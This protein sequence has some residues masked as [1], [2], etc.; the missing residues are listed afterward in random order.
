MQAL[1]GALERL[2][3][4]HGFIHPSIELREIKN[5]LIG[6]SERK[7]WLCKSGALWKLLV[8][9]RE[10]G[11]SLDEASVEELLA[12]LGTLCF[13]GGSI[14]WESVLKD[15]HIQEFLSSKLQRAESPSL[16]LAVLRTVRRFVSTWWLAYGESVAFPWSAADAQALLKL[17][18]RD[19]SLVSREALATVARWA[20][21]PKGRALLLQ[22]D[23]MTL[24]LK[25]LPWALD[26]HH[27]QQGTDS[28][29]TTNR[30]GSRLSTEPE[31]QVSAILLEVLG[32]LVDDAPTAATMLA[33]VIETVPG[34]RALFRSALHDPSSRRRFFGAKTL[35][36]LHLLKALSL[37]SELGT[38]VLQVLLD[39]LQTSHLSWRDEAWSHFGLYRDRK[40]VPLL[41]YVEETGELLAKLLASSP[42]LQRIAFELDGMP[43][44]VHVLQHTREQLSACSMNKTTKE[45]KRSR[46]WR[47]SRSKPDQVRDARD[48]ISG[49]AMNRAQRRL[50]AVLQTMAFIAS[51]VEQAS[52][53]LADSKLLDLLMELLESARKTPQMT[54]PGV[55]E[56]VVQVLAT[57]MGSAHNRRCQYLQPELVKHLL[58][59]AADSSATF[60]VRAAA[61]DAL[62]QCC[63]PKC[64]LRSALFD[65]S[66]GISCLMPLLRAYVDTEKGEQAS[67]THAD[68]TAALGPVTRAAAWTTSLHQSKTS[69]VATPNASARWTSFGDRT[70]HP[71]HQLVTNT[72]KIM[73]V[74]AL[75]ASTAEKKMLVEQIG[76][77]TLGALVSAGQPVSIRAQAWALIHNLLYTSKS[78]LEHEACLQ[79]VLNGPLNLLRLL[80]DAIQQH[81]DANIRVHALSCL[82]TIAAAEVIPLRTNLLSHRRLLER[83][84]RHLSAAEVLERFLAASCF[85]NLTRFMPNELDAEDILRFQ[86]KNLHDDADLRDDLSA[87]SADHAAKLSLEAIRT[88]LHQLGILARL[89]EI[90]LH[91]TAAD[92]RERARVALW[93]ACQWQRA[94]GDRV[95]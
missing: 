77:H 19:D 16:A 74:L 66:Q 87:S 60:A 23:A 12:V 73:R 50:M 27:G 71:E 72:L 40:A 54:S 45:S 36:H 5:S 57:L 48:P 28:G 43:A 64:R 93:N 24:V 32:V 83:I 75:S 78:R 52:R 79:L 7:A 70:T 17:L 26:D 55:A 80:E 11:Q 18:Q 42:L 89:R 49:E 95:A 88:R 21:H 59:L 29:V 65:R 94:C 14:A 61:S 51:N 67:H 41:L 91:D 53:M 62:A 15:E 30:Y 10:K 35:V 39:L 84:A 56:A 20:V 82:V 69:I 31:S 68:L 8:F 2:E 37:E 25:H 86:K 38:T 3:G 92:V 34:C 9:V 63:M 85:A 4:D 6:S 47:H 81:T 90:A 76:W 44:L 33:N 13:S 1:A 58:A 46:L 22:S